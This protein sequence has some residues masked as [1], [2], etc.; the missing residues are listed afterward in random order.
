MSE[1]AESHTCTCP[2]PPL[3]QGRRRDRTEERAQQLCQCTANWGHLTPI[4]AIHPAGC[5]DA[6]HNRNDQPLPCILPPL[7]PRRHCAHVTGWEGTPL[8]MSVR[9]TAPCSR[10]FRSSIIHCCISM[11][12]GTNIS[13]LE[14]CLFSYKTTGCMRG[15]QMF[16]LLCYGIWNLWTRW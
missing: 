15:K 7:F 10:A 1:S 9:N 2:P 4:T 14:K 3:P 6:C 11:Q 16:K 13:G 5:L 8:F 12:R